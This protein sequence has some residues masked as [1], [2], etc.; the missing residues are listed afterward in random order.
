MNW[1]QLSLIAHQMLNFKCNVSEFWNTTA[2]REVNWSEESLLLPHC[3]DDGLQRRWQVLCWHVTMTPFLIKS[4][5]NTNISLTYD[6]H[7][8]N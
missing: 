8:D 7:N 5:I 6:T 4:L 1:Y 3:S 2:L